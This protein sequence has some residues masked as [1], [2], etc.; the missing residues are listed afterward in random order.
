MLKEKF[1]FCPPEGRRIVLASASPRRKDLLK[2][3][4]INN[5]KIEPA[6]IDEKELSKELPNKYVLGIAKQ[7]AEVVSNNNQQCFV[8][9]ADTIVTCGRRILHKTETRSDA[10]NCLNLLSGRRHKVLSAV[11]INS[12]N[13]NQIYRTVT[14]VVTF[15]KLDKEELNIYLGTDEWEGKAGG[16]AIQGLAAT[17]IRAL[18]GSYSNVVGLPLH[19][20]YQ[21][22][23][24]MGF[25][26]KII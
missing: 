8:I 7:K 12:P 26:H 24:G 15:K 17:Y 6:D 20:T 13:G 16:Y 1:V 14:S 10:S 25:S 9:A 18:N 23:K 3:I 5:F 21:L 22:L 2:Q 19:E 4:G 11:V